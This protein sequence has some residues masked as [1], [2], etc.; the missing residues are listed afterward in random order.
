MDEQNLPDGMNEQGATQ[1]DSGAVDAPKIDLQKAAPAQADAQPENLGEPVPDSGAGAIKPDSKKLPAIIGAVIVVLV[2]AIVLLFS[3]VFSSGDPKAAVDKA[4]KATGKAMQARADQ[5]MEEVPGMGMMS[6][7]E[8]KASKTAYD[9]QLVGIEADVAGSKEDIALINSLLAGAG[10]RGGIVSDPENSITELSGSLHLGDMDLVELYGYISPDLL[11]FNIPTFSDTVLSI[12]P[13]TFAQDYKNSPLNDGDASD[14]ELQEMQDLLLSELGMS[15]AFYGLDYKQMQADMYAIAG[16][17]LDNAAYEK[18]EK[19]DGLRQYVIKVPGKD[20]KTFFIELLNYIYVDSALGQM[21]SGML[22]TGLDGT[23]SFAD[24]FT[25]ELIEPLQ[26]GMPEMDTTITIGVGAKN[27]I[28][29]MHFEMTPPSEPIDGVTIES[30]TADFN[31]AESGDETI[32]AQ[33]V[34]SQDGETMTIAMDVSDSYQNGVYD[35]DFTMNMDAEKAP[36]SMG[37]AANE[38]L[39]VNMV[40]GMT[41]DKDGKFDMNIH[42]GVPTDVLTGEFAYDIGGS[43]TITTDGGKTTYD[44]PTLSASV[45]AAGEKMG[46]TFSLKADSEPL[47]GPYEFSGVHTSLFGMT[48]EELDAEAQKYTDGLNAML[49]KLLP[50]IMSASMG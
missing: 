45:T 6:N 50:L 23:D 3:G 36:G 11:A 22:A 35:V 2:A 48:T 33:A 34:L 4:F 5:I 37:D 14:E 44:F 26:A 25:K 13:Q 1:P 12:N 19:V 49:G 40:V 10:I 15:G 47:E 29:T 28:Q 27:Q 7:F 9:L 41:A 38:A 30:L 32:T 31:I 18:G 21:Y 43:G 20:V 16:K 8:P 17:A 39:A 42:L 24:M 46:I